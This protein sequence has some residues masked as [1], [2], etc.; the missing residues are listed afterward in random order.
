[1][2]CIQQPVLIIF[3]THFNSVTFGS[4][5]VVKEQM[6]NSVIIIIFNLVK[7]W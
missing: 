2:V 7:V 1:M 5:I 3:V 4:R 6:K